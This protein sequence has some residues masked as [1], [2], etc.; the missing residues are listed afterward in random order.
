[1]NIHKK[2]IFIM[3]QIIRLKNS[4]YQFH[5]VKKPKLY[6]F[7]MERFA[8]F[9][10]INFDSLKY[11][12]ENYLKKEVTCEDLVN[13]F[14]N[15]QEKK[16]QVFDTVINMTT[17]FIK[18]LFGK[19]VKDGAVYNINLQNVFLTSDS[20]ATFGDITISG[21]ENVPNETIN[22]LKEIM[23]EPL[24]KVEKT[25]NSLNNSIEKALYTFTPT[26]C[27]VEKEGVEITVEVKD[28][29]EMLKFFIKYLLPFLSDKK[30]VEKLDNK[31]FNVDIDDKDSMT[32]IGNIAKAQK[33]SFNTNSNLQNEL[34]A[35]I[36]ESV[37][38]SG[39]VNN[40][41]AVYYW[42]MMFAYGD[43]NEM[44]ISV[45]PQH[46]QKISLHA[47]ALIE[48]YKQQNIIMQNNFHSKITVQV[49]ELVIQQIEE[50]TVEINERK[51]LTRR[52]TK[53]YVNKHFKFT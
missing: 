34:S 16:E 14:L 6:E 32:F 21:S 49:S 40:F 24:M 48:I 7:I 22:K 11:F 41:D 9:N 46:F 52:I 4:F 5:Q 10:Y 47:R 25:I 19:T 37:S 51:Q 18:K 17:N 45:P 42:A 30:T 27:D 35:T 36:S 15:D 12:L 2:F 44:R 8:I 29:N 38:L 43:L 31:W 20:I 26:I 23:V 33:K 50:L 13:I 3:L 1:M 53:E 39:Q 28:L